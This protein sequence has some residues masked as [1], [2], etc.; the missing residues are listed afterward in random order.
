MHKSTSFLQDNADSFRG[1][2]PPWHLDRAGAL[3]LVI[4]IFTSHA[5]SW[6]QVVSR[7]Q[8]LYIV[9]YSW[10]LVLLNWPV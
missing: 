10:S 7:F 8:S 9:L 4:S 2:L 6:W 3:P 1:P 5:R